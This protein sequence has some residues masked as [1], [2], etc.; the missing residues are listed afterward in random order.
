[1]SWGLF[2]MTLKPDNCLDVCAAGKKVLNQAPR[3][4]FDYTGIYIHPATA[5]AAAGLAMLLSGFR[6]NKNKLS[7]ET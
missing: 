7:I 5:A 3:T 2:S 1:M 6:G 4:A